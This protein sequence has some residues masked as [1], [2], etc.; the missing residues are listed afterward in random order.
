M[1][2]EETSRLPQTDKRC[3]NT[4]NLRH[5]HISAPIKQKAIYNIDIIH[6]LLLLFYE[7][8]FY[9]EGIACMVT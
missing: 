6:L 3:E 8:F 9:E 1:H 7:D 4:T 2:K 5:L